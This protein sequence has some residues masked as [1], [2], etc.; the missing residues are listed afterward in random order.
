MCWRA[1][2][3]VRDVMACLLPAQRCPAKIRD[4]DCL[5][6]VPSERP[7]AHDGRERFMI[8]GLASLEP[9]LIQTSLQSRVVESRSMVDD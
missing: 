9:S 6:D 4:V 8:G 7:L 1:R 5:L 3:S 2:L